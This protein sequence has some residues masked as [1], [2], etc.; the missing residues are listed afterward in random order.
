MGKNI[1]VD[2]AHW[3]SSSQPPTQQNDGYYLPI[4]FMTVENVVMELCEL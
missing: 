4:L 3:Q 1:G 2:V